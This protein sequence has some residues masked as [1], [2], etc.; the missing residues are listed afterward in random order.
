MFKK[1]EVREENFSNLKNEIA[2]LY[3]EIENSDKSE[4]QKEVARKILQKTEQLKNF[5]ENV[6]KSAFD[7][8][9]E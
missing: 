7:D 4:T 6:S 5:L 1:K 3:K 8:T 2:E 9:E